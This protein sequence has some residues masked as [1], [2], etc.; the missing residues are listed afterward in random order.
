MASHSLVREVGKRQRGCLVS[1]MTAGAI[2]TWVGL[3]GPLQRIIFIAPTA[4]CII[5]TDVLHA[6]AVNYHKIQGGV[7][8]VERLTFREVIVDTADHQ[9]RLPV[10][11]C[12]IDTEFQ[13]VK[14][15]PQSWG[16]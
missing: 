4:K 9:M 7:V 5:S 8:P 12:C 10:V 15:K 1:V 13:E 2:T 6:C 16:L 3:F 11:R 14:R